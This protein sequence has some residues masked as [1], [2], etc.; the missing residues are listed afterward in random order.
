MP[1]SNTTFGGTGNAINT[2]G[3]GS[4]TVDIQHQGIDSLLQNLDRLEHTADKFFG[5]LAMVGQGPPSLL[6]AQLVSMAQTCQQMDTDANT[7]SLLNVP[8]AVT[9]PGV[10]ESTATLPRSGAEQAN[11]EL[12]D[13]VALDEWVQQ[14]AKQTGSLFAERQRLAANVQAALSV[15]HSKRLDLE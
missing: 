1:A 3:S 4:V 12:K 8:T 10:I 5:S 13:T 11:V 14:T 9:D 2:S 15:P 7:T 6:A